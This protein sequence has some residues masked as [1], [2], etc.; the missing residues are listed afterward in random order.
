MENQLNFDAVEQNLNDLAKIAETPT[1]IC[2]LAYSPAF[3]KSNAFIEKL[4]KEAGLAVS[5]SKVGNV[6]GTL[7]GEN[8]H[9]IAIG[10]HIDSVVNAG[11]YY[12]CLGV[13]G[14]IEVVS[15][16]KREGYTPKHS[17]EVCAWAEEEGLTI[18]GLVG[19]RAYCGLEPT[20]V[21]KEK[22]HDFGFDETDFSHAKSSDPI[23][24]SLELHIE[25]GGVL[26][27]RQIDIGVVSA[28]IAQKRYW[29]EFEGVANHAGTTP[30]TLRSDAL[31]KAARFITRTS[32]IVREID[33]NMVGTVGRIEVFPNAVN[34][35]P[36]KVGLTLELRSL[37]ERSIALAYEKLM[38]EFRSE[39]SSISLTMEQPSYQMDPAVRAAIHRAAELSGCSACDMGSG[40]GHDS[41]SLAQV[42]RAGMIFVPSVKGISHSREEKTLQADVRKGV[43]VLYNTVKLLDANY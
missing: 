39:I 11:K 24:F 32:E 14:G 22:M 33:S 30:M 34:T 9:K 12:G 38:S 13:L 26:E 15:A 17:I 2:R 36:G 27:S 19:S 1:G 21:M 43:Q 35:V 31:V 25:Q 42:T 5:T 37:N 8:S 7:K 16:L 18:A 3:W 41:M 4:M 23:D 20:E 40:A 29:V 6:V 10:S 28:I